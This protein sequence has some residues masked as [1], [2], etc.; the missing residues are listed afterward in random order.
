MKKESNLEII[1]FEEIKKLQV[2]VIVT[3]KN[4]L[5]FFDSRI[6]KKVL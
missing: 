3:N 5:I 4:D 6:N 1:Y 2:F